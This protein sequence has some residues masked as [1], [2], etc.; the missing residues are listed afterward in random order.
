VTIAAVAL[1]EGRRTAT[2]A[3]ENAETALRIAPVGV[4]ETVAPVNTRL[5]VTTIVL[6]QASWL[7]VLS[8][9]AYKL[10]A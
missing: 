4:G 9:L 3:A 8:F 6:V 10:V 5:V 7:S 1:E 2:Q